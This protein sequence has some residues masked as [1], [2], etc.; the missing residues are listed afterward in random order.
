MYAEASILYTGND[1]N[2]FQLQLWQEKLHNAI[3]AFVLCIEHV[4]L[5]SSPFLLNWIQKI[6]HL[7]IFTY[8]HMCIPLWV[9]Q[10]LLQ[11]IMLQFQQIS[12]KESKCSRSENQ[13]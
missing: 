7:C 2:S 10:S 12:S 1:A 3:G 5:I 11:L 4:S 6:G 13:G 9:L 8:L